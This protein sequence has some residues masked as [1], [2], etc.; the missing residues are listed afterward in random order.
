MRGYINANNANFSQIHIN[1]SPQ[2]VLFL[3]IRINK[4]TH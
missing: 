4:S 1:K 2:N 3:S